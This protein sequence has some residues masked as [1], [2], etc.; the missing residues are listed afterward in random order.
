MQTV[1]SAE[2]MRWCDAT[3]GKSYGIPSLLL[4]ENAG[5]SVA[6]FI[7]ERYGSVW[8][9]DILIFCGK[10]NNGG[11]G[12][13]VARHLVNQGAS[14]HLMMTASPRMLKGDPKTNFRIL[15]QL[16]KSD[17]EHLHIHPYSK[18][19]LR[20]L[21]KP[22][23]IVDALLGTGFAGAVREP[24]GEVIRWINAQQAPVVAVDIPSG[25]NASNGVVENVA[26]EASATVTFGLLKV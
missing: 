13:V 24:L 12:F 2:E 4:M 8:R 21:P 14:V 3:A 22:Y 7:E 23:V 20:S 26:V 25:V 17:P 6:W 11:D 16:Q 19:L 5:S 9:K 18:R 15:A 10:G 1:V